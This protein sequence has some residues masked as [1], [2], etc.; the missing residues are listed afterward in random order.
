M[1]EILVYDD[2]RM[3]RLGPRDKKEY[4]EVTTEKATRIDI[5]DVAKGKGK[6]LPFGRTEQKQLSGK[7]LF[8][9]NAEYERMAVVCKFTFHVKPN[10]QYTISTNCPQSNTANLYVNSNSSSSKA[11]I[12]SPKTITSDENG[13]FYISLRFAGSQDDPNTF[14]LFHAVQ[15]GE[16]WIQVEEGATATDY[17]PYVG[18]TASP[19]PD[20]PQEIRNV[21]GRSCRNLFDFKKY[22]I[23]TGASVLQEDGFYLTNFN[24]LYRLYRTDESGIDLNFKENTQ[25]TINFIATAGGGTGTGGKVIINY[26]DDTTSNVSISNS[27][28]NTIRTLVSAANKTIKSISFTY[29]SHRNDYIKDFQINE[30]SIALPYEPYFEGKKLELNV[31][32]KNLFDENIV[33]F[34]DGLLDDNGQPITGAS[35]YTKN[36]YPAKPNTLYNL[37]GTTTTGTATKRIYFYNQKKEWIS[38]SSAMETN[39]TSFT[40]PANCYYVRLQ[41]SN[42]VTLK[43]GDVML[44]EGTDNTYVEH[45]QQLIPFPL[46]EGQKLMEGDY[47]ADDG[48]HHLF[49]QIILDGT[50][51]WKILTSTV[52]YTQFTIAQSALSR[53]KRNGKVWSNYFIQTKND[54]PAL[55]NVYVGYSYFNVCLDNSI[56]STVKGF[57]SWLANKY[58]NNNPVLIQYETRSE[59]IDA[60]TEAQQ[61][62]YNKLKNLMLYKDVN[63]IWTNTDG[64]EPNLQL[65]Y[66]RIKTNGVLQVSNTQPF[67]NLELNNTEETPEELDV[68]INESEVTE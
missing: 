15:N 24:T 67:N 44:C 43:T 34:I 63:H 35:H 42:A 54:N 14:D 10:T 29:S 61:E 20:Y 55:N 31:C 40:T 68:I 66:K 56:A 11:Y 18:G 39:Y 36:F 7:N 21:E 1:R 33:E 5:T 58:S 3:H 65:T 13:E 59:I 19:N 37:I 28:N 38:R 62:A 60:Y 50:E 17:E 49:N 46:Q 16:Y 45:K 4:E 12:N 47:L 9:I 57:K 51:D 22:C 2:Y 48:V 30:G 8:D 27:D 64:L 41:V 52:S 53:A 23:D 25:Y 26:T 32:N 6:L